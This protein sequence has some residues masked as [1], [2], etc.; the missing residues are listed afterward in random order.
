LKD[1]LFQVQQVA[2]TDS[3]V[4][5]KGE[6]GTDKERFAMAIH[7]KSKRNNHAFIKVN[8]HSANVNHELFG[9]EKGA[10]VGAI[11]KKLGRIEVAH[12]G[13]LYLEEI[14]VL[15]KSDQIQL[16]Q[17]IEEGYFERIGS[18]KKRKVNVR[19]IASTQN[20]I[21]DLMHKGH[22]L[23]ELFYRINAYP[24]SI[25]PLRNR[26]E[27][28]PLIAKHYAQVFN[29]KLGK[30]IKRISLKNMKEL[31]AYSWPGNVLELQNIIERAVI[32]SHGTLLYV[33]PFL[34]DHSTN[35]NRHFIPLFEYE[36]NYLIEVL[37]STNWRISG[38]KGAAQILKI[39]PETL[40]SRLRKLKITRP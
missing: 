11:Q 26:P 3:I 8:C 1:A 18:A 30:N 32:V 10:F 12:K 9:Y 16:L 40:R 37:K 4:L 20:N 7:Q 5:L 14:E 19:I 34:R 29:K 13:T 36:R 17:F 35:K 2:P 22:F 27:D 38:P 21:E 6:T 39:H 31:Q 33:E 25:A 28:I 15:P 23:K 24:I